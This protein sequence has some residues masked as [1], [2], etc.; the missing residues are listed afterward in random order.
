ML[1]VM[2]FVLMVWGVVSQGWWLPQMAASFPHCR[3]HH[4]IFL[5][6]GLD[7]KTVT[8]KAFINGAFD[9]VGVSLIIGLPHVVLT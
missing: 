1:F 2:A 4:H 8:E 3:H 5:G 9:L 6:S 7:E